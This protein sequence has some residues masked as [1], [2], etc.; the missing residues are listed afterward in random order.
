MNRQNLRTIV[1]VLSGCALWAID[2]A[3]PMAQSKGKETPVTA[4]QV[5]D[6]MVKAMQAK[7]KVEAWES[8]GLTS[9]LAVGNLVAD[10][11]LQ[12]S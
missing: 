3:A 7:R 11:A 5:F 10:L 6:E 1:A 4:A 12:S 9:C 8:P 2:G